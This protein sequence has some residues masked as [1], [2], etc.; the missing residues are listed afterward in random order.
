[1]G[2]ARLRVSV[3]GV[4]LALLAS[5]CTWGS[6]DPAEDDAEVLGIQVERTGDAVATTTPTEEPTDAVSPS[7]SSSPAATGTSAPG[8]GAP[9]GTEPE[10][11]GDH[12]HGTGAPTTAAPVGP[13]A[14][15]PSPS[16][17]PE[18]TATA[19]P[20]PSPSPT[21][22]ALASREGHSYLTWFRDEEP[23]GQGGSRYVWGEVSAAPAVT[24]DGS[25]PLRVTLVDLAGDPDRS[26]PRRAQCRAWLEVDGDEAVR[27]EGELTVAVVVDGEV[28]SSGTRAVAVTV[29]PG[30][31]RDL[32][33]IGDVRVAVPDVAEV[34]CRV[35]F[36]AEA[37]G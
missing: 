18:P 24:R 25:E 14:P 13:V 26:A 30:E 16:P 12:E 28:A 29:A 37:S 27:A 10:A 15:A 20:T 11:D 2:I 3:A 31:R 36:T 5:A 9:T 34:T 33:A 17:S 32:V 19:S 4:L 23:D 8:A 1:M 35:R 21:P 6:D 7:P 22:V